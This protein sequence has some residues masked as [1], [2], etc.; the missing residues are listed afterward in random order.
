VGQITEFS[1]GL[2]AV[3]MPFKV[4]PGPDGNA[5]FNDDHGAVGQV[6]AQGQITEY[7][8]GL[9]PGSNPIWVAP[10]PDGNIWFADAG[11]KGAIGRIT[12]QG[13]ITEFSTGLNTGSKPLGLTP[14]ADGDLWFTDTGTIKTIGKIDPATD[15]ITELPAANLPQAPHRSSSPPGLTATCGSATPG[16]ARSAASCRRAVMSTSSPPG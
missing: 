12:P 1:T 9:N 10:G 13:Q 8:T 11:T 16:R 2:T 5:W 15:Q 6:T 4:A 14:A 7:S 3:S